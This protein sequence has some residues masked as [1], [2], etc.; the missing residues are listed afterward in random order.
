[1]TDLDGR[2]RAEGRRVEYEPG[3]LV[4]LF[5]EGLEGHRGEESRR[6]RRDD[7]GWEALSYDEVGERVR[8][9]ALGLQALGYQRGDRI[10]I[11]SDT[12]M[13]WAL[14]DFSLLMSGVVSV[15]VYPSLTAEQSRYILDD[16]GA[17]A[18]FVADQEQYDKLAEVAGQLPGMERVFGFDPLEPTPSGPEAMALEEL[19]ARGREAGRELEEGYE[20]R[21]REAAPDDLATLIY[22]SGTTGAPKGVMLTHA[23]FHSNVL[24]SSRVLS[25]G[26]ED[27][28]LSWLPLSHVF[29]RQAGHYL[30]W[31]QGV[32]VAYAESVETVA[33]DMGEVGPTIMTAVPRLYEKVVERA[34]AAAREGGAL[35]EKIF[36]WARRV[37]EARA[38][39]VL[40][41]RRPGPL[42]GVQYALADRLVFRK[43]RA[44]TGGR[45]RYF[46]SGGAPLSP[47]VGR[48]FWGAGLP[49]LEG[50]GLTETSPVLCVNPP[51][52]PKLGTVGPPIP[53]TELRI[54]GDGE[55]LARGPQVMK[56][57]Y[58]NEEAT[59]ETITEGGWLRTGDVGELDADGYLRITDRKKELIVLATGKKVAPSPVENAVQRSR[60][61][62]Y[63]VLM[64]DERKFPLVVVQPAFEEV[65][66]WA[67]ESGVAAAGPDELVR[68]GEVQELL[69]EEVSEQVREFAHHETP[70]RVLLVS[71]R[72]GVKS[73]E[74]TPTMKVKR[75]V[76][77]E[78]Y[79]DEI[80]RVYAE[81]EA[82]GEG[83]GRR[84]FAAGER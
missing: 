29:E 34:E 52:R 57:Y 22:T 36:R 65:E 69:A 9:L 53:N 75:R 43:L 80:D 60:F 20:E 21:A 13:E 61:V 18:A 47:E 23:N 8:R 72:F 66:A 55:I 73:G 64:G 2:K 39:R 16:A 4:D 68:S 56:G 71:D 46:I 54:D 77:A 63:A 62:E 81:A 83:G 17:R 38:D 78:R 5:L 10:A 15:P 41:G 37:G 33:R 11:L 45:V 25:V 30:M 49:V 59:A 14:A 28:S 12:R 24:M 19:E 42:L 70:G 31:R 58:R 82:A 26:P 51:E 35:K 84:V 76:I 44:R 32:T 48:F 3:T 40:A 74:L 50:Y 79:A 67:S 1:M 27:V 6:V 7:G